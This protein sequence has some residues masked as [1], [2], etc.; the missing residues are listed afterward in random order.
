MEAKAKKKIT[1]G[2]STDMPLL[3]F[4]WDIFRLLYYF[5]YFFWW[6]RSNTNLNRKLPP[7]GKKKWSPNSCGKTKKNSNKIDASVQLN[8]EQQQA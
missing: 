3:S 8:G 2:E 1:R 4:A 7:F 5:D 6:L